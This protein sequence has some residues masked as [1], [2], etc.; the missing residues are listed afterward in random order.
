MFS[1]ETY[2]LEDCLYY[3]TTEYSGTNMTTLNITMPST[4][5]LEFDFKPTS[6]SSASSYVEVGTSTTN[7]LVIGQITSSGT[8]GIWVRVNNNYS[9][10]N[11]A[12]TSSVLSTDNHVTFTFDG[13]DCSYT[14]NSETVTCSKPSYDL[15]KLL[16]VAPYT[17]NKLKNI[18][19][20][21]L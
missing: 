17:N 12:P 6:R 5:K 14:C 7:C 19:I 16:R 11:P 21:P 10:T 3:K 2:S 9:S 13:T 4:F 15:E 20:K 1:S 8:H 18:K